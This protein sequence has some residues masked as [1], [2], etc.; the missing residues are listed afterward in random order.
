MLLNGLVLLWLLIIWAL[1][2][3]PTASYYSLVAGA[4]ACQAANRYNKLSTPSVHHLL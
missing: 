1:V 4:C 3:G 2:T